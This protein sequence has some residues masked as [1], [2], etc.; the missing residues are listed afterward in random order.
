MKRVIVLLTIGLIAVYGIGRYNLGESGAMRFM[1]DMES[2]MG[3]G[4]GAAV[5]DMFHDDL[6]VEVIDH[7]GEQLQETNGGKKEF[8][9]LT[10]E[11][12]AG[13]RMLPHSMSV[14][15]TDVTAKQGL[16][17]PWTSEVSYDE[18]RTLTIQGANVSLRT[19][20][21]DEITLVQTLTGVKLRKVKSEVY[22]ADA[23]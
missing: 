22:K 15:Y 14:N 5:C 18:H 6:E 7:S 4:N 2:H 8:C 17:S 10:R 11:T 9:A 20:S 21:N 19:V 12:A 23:V 13:L 16:A 1:A 3:A